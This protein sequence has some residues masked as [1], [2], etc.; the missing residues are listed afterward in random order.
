[1]TRRG[2]APRGVPAPE[3][4]PEAAP[5]V[6]PHGLIIA[7]VRASLRFTEHPAAAGLASAKAVALARGAIHAMMI[8][9]LKILGAAAL[10]CVLTVGVI[11][12]FANQPGGTALK[13][14][15]E[16]AAVG[17]RAV[18]DDKAKSDREQLQGTW[19]VTR[20]TMGGKEEAEHGLNGTT[21]TFRRDELAVD[22]H[23]G[24]ERHTFK[25]DTS[26]DPRAMFTDRIE[27]DRPQSGWMIYELKGN[28]LKIGFND[29]LI[30]KPEGFAPR[31]K[32][33]VL[34]LER[35]TKAKSEGPDK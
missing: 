17:R 7:T 8:S 33:I 19:V 9:R 16:P 13:G 2:L 23:D 30:G 1:M 14:G 18:I 34:E 25:L 12:T 15:D 6:I 32:L 3:I 21:M 31:A 35:D 22:S 29:A 4:S 10:A 26:S 11:C 27:P 20:T 24:K 5:V 28:R